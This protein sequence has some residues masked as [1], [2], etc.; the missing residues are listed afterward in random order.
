MTGDKLLPSIREAIRQCGLRDG[1]TV[2]FHHHLRDGDGVLPMVMGVIGE[3]GFRNIRVSASSIHASHGIVADLIRKGV[4][5][6]IDTNFLGRSVGDTVSAGFMPE[7]AVLRTHGGRPLALEAGE[8]AIDIAFIA[9]SAAD[10]MG[11]M[12]GVDGPSAF[13]SMGHAFADAAFAEKVVV[14]TNHLVPYPLHRVSIDETHV[15]HVVVVPSL[16]DVAGIK[17]GLTTMTRDPMG[18]RIARLAADAVEHSGLLADGFNY[19]SGGGRTSQAVT[20]FVREAMKRRK[21]TG[22]FLLGGINSLAVA[23]LEEGL[24]GSALDAQCFDLEAV[25]SLRRNPSH[26]EIS[27]SRYANYNAPSRCCAQLGAVVLGATEIDVN[28][29]VNVHTESLGIIMGGSGGHSDI[30]KGAELTVIVTPLVRARSSVV[31]EKVACRS[32]PGEC[33]D[34]LVT[35]YGIAVNPAR[36]ELRARLAEAGLPLKD[37]EELLA[38]ARRMTGTP[39]PVAFGEKIVAEVVGYDGKRTDVIRQA[40]FQE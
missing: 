27:C 1:M 13:G 39:K 25:D 18:L 3:M 26:T 2:S 15:D 5:D 32:T 16:G 19:Q 17:S 12:N 10:R 4:V 8:T 14:V 24:F 21:V 20:Q 6:R 7:P 36:P 30:A 11:N 29:D 23:M 33:V 35:Q 22:G 9:A 31:V 37:I 28:F 40:V 38:I 34:L